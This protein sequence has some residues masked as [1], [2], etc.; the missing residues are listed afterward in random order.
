MAYIR[1]FADVLNFISSACMT[2]V[3]FQ[4]FEIS[5]MNIYRNFFEKFLLPT[6]SL[7]SANGTF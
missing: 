1:E 2:L 5:I 7:G 3:I 4:D 6:A